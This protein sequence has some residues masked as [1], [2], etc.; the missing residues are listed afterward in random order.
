MESL[1]QYEVNTID[2]LT[3]AVPSR[4]L[5]PK[6]RT[7]LGQNAGTAC[8]CPLPIHLASRWLSILGKYKYGPWPTAIDCRVQLA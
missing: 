1:E 5:G 6:M 7:I 2:I 8:D 4:M 3:L